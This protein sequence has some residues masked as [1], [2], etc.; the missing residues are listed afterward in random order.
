MKSILKYAILT[1]LVVLGTSVAANAK[2][3]D[4]RFDPP[5]PPRWDHDDRKDWKSNDPKA[6]EVDPSLAVVG[7]SLLAGS[8]TVL[9][10]RNRK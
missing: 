1:L 6:P 3:E 4:H 8:L 10:A 7:F 2:P 9:R 5:P